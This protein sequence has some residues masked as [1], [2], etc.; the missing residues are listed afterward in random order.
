MTGFIPLRKYN[1]ELQVDIDNHYKKISVTSCECNSNHI[2]HSH[3]EIANIRPT[4]TQR[5]TSPLRPQA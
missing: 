4:R 5:I 2:G 3:L 1:L